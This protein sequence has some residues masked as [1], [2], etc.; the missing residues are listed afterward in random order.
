MSAEELYSTTMDPANRHLVQLT[1]DDMQATLD[2]YDRL[3]GKSAQLR[4]DFII[5][6]RLSSIKGDD[7]LFE[8]EEYDDDDIE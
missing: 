7:D 6:N 8:E 4:R 2:L 1:T 5:Q 3:M